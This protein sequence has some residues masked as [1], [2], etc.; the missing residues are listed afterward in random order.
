MR[1]SRR[2]FSSLW[3]VPPSPQHTHTQR[4]IYANHSDAAV[5]EKKNDCPKKA[6]SI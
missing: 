6:T 5:L 4:Y 2:S 3:A 1:I